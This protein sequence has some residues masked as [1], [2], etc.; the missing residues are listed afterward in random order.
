MT[1]TATVKPKYSTAKRRASLY[2]AAKAATP[3]P[4]QK[5]NP[6]RTRLGNKPLYGTD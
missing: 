5:I 6:C 1:A 2:R 3:A 4:R